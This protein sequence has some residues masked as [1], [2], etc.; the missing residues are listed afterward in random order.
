M[1]SVA[2]V[3]FQGP[4]NKWNKDSIRPGPVGTVGDVLTSVRIKQS[5]PDADFAWSKKF[6]PKNSMLRGSNVQDGR[7]VSFSDAGYNAQVKKKRLNKNG[8]F[9]TAT[10]FV[11]QNIIPEARAMQPKL[12]DQPGQGWKNQAAEIMQRKGDIFT[13]LPGG[14]GPIIPTRGGQFPRRINNSITGNLEALPTTSSLLDSVVFKP[15][16]IQENIKIKSE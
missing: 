5:Y 12:L 9:R 15:S 14:Y 7:W 3:S 8:S 4:L 1:T 10:G 11:F 6:N 2:T 16:Q 13:T